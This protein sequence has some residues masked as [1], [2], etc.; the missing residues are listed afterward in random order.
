MDGADGPDDREQPAERGVLRDDAAARESRNGVP[1]APADGP[2][3]AAEHDRLGRRPRSTART[4][5]R[6]CVYRFPSDTAV[7]GPAQIEAQIDADPMISSQ[8]TLW[9]QSGSKVVRGEPDR[10]ARR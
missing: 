7:F 5:A 6:R 3:R 9:N 10:R 4:T 8:F 2:A 1:A